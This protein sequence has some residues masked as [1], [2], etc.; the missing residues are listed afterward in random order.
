MVCKIC[1]FLLKIQISRFSCMNQSGYS[2]FI[3]LEQ[4]APKA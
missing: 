2:D 4:L 3:Q 1:K